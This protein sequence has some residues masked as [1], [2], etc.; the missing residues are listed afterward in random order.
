MSKKTRTTESFKAELKEINNNVE[1]LGEYITT[2][3]K[4]QC[5]CKICGTEQSPIPKTLL[6]GIGCPECG[7]KKCANSNRKTLDKLKEELSIK[8]PNIEYYSGEYKN[9][10]SNLFFR[11]KLCGEKR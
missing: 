5:K 1:V 6:K 9:T 3:A 4:I 2:N 10:D 11:C 7:K 8:C